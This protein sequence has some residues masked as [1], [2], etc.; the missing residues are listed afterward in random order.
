MV[1]HPR[2]VN[3]TITTR[4]KVDADGMVKHAL[5]LVAES[6]NVSPVLRITTPGTPRPG[7]RFF[8][9]PYGAISLFADGPNGVS[10]SAGSG[11]YVIHW[12]DERGRRQRTI[13]QAWNG[14]ELDTVE[15]RDSE[16]QLMDIARAANVRVDS[17][18]FRTPRRSPPVVSIAFD[19]DGRLWVE[20]SVPRGANRLSDVYMPNGKYWRT[21]KWPPLKNIVFLG[22]A[23][24][25]TIWAYFSDEDGTARLARLDIVDL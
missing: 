19:L 24:G 8:Y 23:R 7:A 4:W 2:D 6:T 10:A 15:R 5:T 1:S 21:V 20:K 17:L 3:S 11:A 25:R 14:A 12:F 16:K 22:A 13:H 9:A 18:P